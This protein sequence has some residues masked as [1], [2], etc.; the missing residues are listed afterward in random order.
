[1]TFNHFVSSSMLAF[2]MLSGCSHTP[3]MASK[4]D[5]QAERY[6]IDCSR[7]WAE[8]VVTGDRSKRRIYFAEDFIGTDTK[9]RRYDKSQV[10]RETGPAKQIISNTLDEVSVRFFGDTA[11][12]HGSETWTRKDGSTG[13]YVWTDIWVKRSGQWQIITAQDAAAPVLVPPRDDGT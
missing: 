7:D 8:S 11:I 3:G 9:G 1:M 13:R 10:T 12:A 4:S 6:I 2:L 5:A